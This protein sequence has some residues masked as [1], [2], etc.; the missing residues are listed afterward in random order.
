MRPSF[1]IM[2]PLLKK[3]YHIDY[4]T[5][6]VF[7]QARNRY[8]YTREINIPDMDIKCSLLELCA[9]LIRIIYK[10]NDETQL[11][12]KSLCE[13]LI[14][15]DDFVAVHIRRGDKKLETTLLVLRE[16]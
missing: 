15:P 6:D 14:L 8:K 3:I 4:F 2:V 16:N 1:L 12:I 5:Q 10:F 9:A 11:R 7:T 13:E